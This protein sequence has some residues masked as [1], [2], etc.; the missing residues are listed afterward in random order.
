[1]RPASVLRAV[2]ALGALALIGFGLHGLLTDPYVQDP[3]DVARW[4]VGGVLLH[5][6]LWLPL[7]CLAGAAL[8]RAPWTVR[9]GLVVAAALTAVGLPAVLHAGAGSGNPTVL[10]LPYLRNLLWLLAATALA[11]LLAEGVRRA[12]RAGRWPGRPGRASRRSPGPGSSAAAR[13]R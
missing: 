9:G 5:D 13:R 1:M 10:P 3:L 2:L 12:R 8:R 4:A 7:V 6:G 11:T